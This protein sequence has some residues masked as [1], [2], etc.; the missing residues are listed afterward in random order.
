MRSLKA[1]DHI[2]RRAAV[3][4]ATRPPVTSERC[5][6]RHREDDRRRLILT[7]T[8]TRN[9]L[10][11]FARN[12]SGRG[13]PQTLQRLRCWPPSNDLTAVHGYIG[14]PL[15]FMNRCRQCPFATSCSREC[16][17]PVSARDVRAR[18]VG[19]TIRH[20]IALPRQQQNRRATDE[21]SRADYL[22]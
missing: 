6:R 12:L 3:C 4:A 11:M 16:P 22:V 10:R 18:Y 1:W 20:M 7:V 15:A 17:F 14:L 13:A 8:T 9:V 21:K 19:P 5:Q 2:K